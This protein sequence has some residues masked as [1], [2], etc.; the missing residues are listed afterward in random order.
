MSENLR[1]CPVAD[2]CEQE[3]CSARIPHTHSEWC[4]MEECGAT[5]RGTPCVPVEEDD[6]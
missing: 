5:Y 1:I 6:E 3:N 4:D 2:V